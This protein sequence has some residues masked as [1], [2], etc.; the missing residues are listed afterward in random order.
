MTDDETSQVQN[1][2]IIIKLIAKDYIQPVKYELDF[3]QAH[4]HL[5]SLGFG[6]FQYTDPFFQLDSPP[7]QAG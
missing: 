5:D 3:A 6:F 4:N 1:G 7:P 2:K